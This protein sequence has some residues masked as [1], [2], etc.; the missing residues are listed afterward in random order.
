MLGKPEERAHQGKRRGGWALHR[1][2]V[3][4]GHGRL[5]ED[6]ASVPHAALCSSCRRSGVYILSSEDHKVVLYSQTPGT[7]VPER[8]PWCYQD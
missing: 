5:D 1:A 2:W 8:T 7:L 6:T 3:D 4:P